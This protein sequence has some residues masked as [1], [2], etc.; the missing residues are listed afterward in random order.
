MLNPGGTFIVTYVNFGHHSRELYYPYNNV[1]PVS[2]LP[3][4]PGAPLHDP[5]SVPD[6]TQLETH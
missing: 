1:Q 6:L 3:G 5:E 2:Q 4:R